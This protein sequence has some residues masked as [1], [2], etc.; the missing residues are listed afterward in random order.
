MAMFAGNE[1]SIALNR[2]LADSFLSSLDARRIER[3]EYDLPL[4][5][6][7]E[8]LVIDSGVQYNMLSAGYKALGVDGHDGGMD[9][10]ATLVTDVFLTPLLRDQYGV[11]TP[12]C[13]VY[14]SNDG[15]MYIY[16]YRDPNIAETFRVLDGLPDMIAGSGI[17]QE[18]LNG[19]I[20]ESYAY[21]AM[22]QGELSGAVDAAE[23]V[24]KGRP[25]DEAVTC[26]RQLKQLTPEK[27]ADYK[28]LLEKFSEAGAVRTAGGAAAIKA[29][30]DRYDKILKPFSTA[31]G[32]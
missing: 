11:Y 2:Q 20:L 22:P 8:A 13:S 9:V 23:A 6:K 24:F 7:N 29:E 12:Y 27:L 17:D 16:T 31:D 19:Y 4:P 1:N 14:I 26:M 32:E 30:A 15:G 5:E 3:A 21:Y 18:T 10:L 25:R 28:G